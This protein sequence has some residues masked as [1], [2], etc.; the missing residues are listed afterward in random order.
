MNHLYVLISIL[1]YIGKDFV[2][3]RIASSQN[4]DRKVVELS[5]EKQPIIYT[6][7]DYDS[8]WFYENQLKLWS[9]RWESSGWFCKILTPSDA[10]KYPTYDEVIEKLDKLN[11]EEVERNSYLRYMAMSTLPNGGI[12]GDIDV[13]P[14]HDISEVALPLSQTLEENDTVFT[15]Y[16]IFS[17]SFLYGNFNG[18]NRAT[19]V[20]LENIERNDSRIKKL[21]IGMPQLNTVS[22]VIM[23]DANDVIRKSLN[24]AKHF[25]MGFGYAFT[26]C[27][28]SKDH[29]AIRISSSWWTDNASTNS[30]GWTFMEYYD[31]QCFFNREGTSERLVMLTEHF[32]KR[33]PLDHTYSIVHQSDVINENTKS[34]VRC[35][36]FSCEITNACITSSSGIKLFGSKEHVEQEKIK[37]IGRKKQGFA[38]KNCKNELR[39]VVSR[40][41][42]TYKLKD[43]VA[44]MGVGLFNYP[45][46]DHMQYVIWPLIRANLSHRSKQDVINN[47][48]GEL[49]LEMSDNFSCSAI[50]TP[51]AEK[52]NLYRFIPNDTM[53]CYRQV[54]VGGS[55]NAAKAATN[56]QDDIKTMRS[57]YYNAYN[58]DE[59]TAMDTIV[60]TKSN[61]FYNLD[62]VRNM[63]KKN[64]PRYRIEVVLWEEHTAREQVKMLART[65]LLIGLPSDAFKHNI[66][67]M[68]DHA[69]I[70]SFC[71]KAENDWF[72]LSV[73]KPRKV[74]RNFCKGIELSSASS[75]P[76]VNVAMLQENINGFLLM[77]S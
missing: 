35:N 12:F 57:L 4:L 38:C 26:A 55:V 21:E 54:I 40:G 17:D 32:Q 25:G 39:E 72:F 61:D 20:I 52:V 67:F 15:S 60:I 71:K 50:Y 18:W 22:F 42:G 11:L 75:Q 9:K 8:K 65:K 31:N 23:L 34:E 48:I 27:K 51:V 68:Q 56:F 6:F 70:I 24:H 7:V 76:V 74:H 14:L 1:I 45:C 46:Y 63:I 53:K 64:Y 3:S 49:F 19:K 36:T 29:Y 77:H 16:D 62:E 43:A 44:S 47:G 10:K 33:R 69:G 13:F 37:L 59:A 28:L 5:T 41:E 73:V 66:V 2:C 30:L 58:I